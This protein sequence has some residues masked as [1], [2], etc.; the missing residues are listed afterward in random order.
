M[1]RELRSLVPFEVAVVIAAGSVA[2]PVPA[3]V[4]LLIA[5]SIS[6]WLRGRSWAGVTKGPALYAVI[7]AA[8]GALALVSALMVS[9]PLLEAITD[10]AVQWSTYPIVRGSTTQAIMVAI[11]VGVS[12]VAAE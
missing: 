6:L 5:A 3:A 2:L 11:V 10:S 12:A 9:T 4:P 1:P 7:G 8:A